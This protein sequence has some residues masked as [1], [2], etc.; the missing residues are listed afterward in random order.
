MEQI[1]EIVINIHLQDKNTKI[2]NWNICIQIYVMLKMKQFHLIVPN[3]H[4]LGKNLFFPLSHISKTDVRHHSKII[5]F[6]KFFLNNLVSH[7]W[8][9]WKNC[10]WSFAF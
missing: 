5:L 1:N 4:F 7:I 10:H 8:N 3:V 2:L 6:L 9:I